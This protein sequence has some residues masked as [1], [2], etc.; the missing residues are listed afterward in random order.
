[1]CKEYYIKKAFKFNASHSIKIN[2]GFEPLH[3]HTFIA[4]ITYRGRK[5]QEGIIIDFHELGRFIEREILSTLD[6]SDLNRIFE[7]PTT[8]NIAEYI[9]SRADNFSSTLELVEVMVCESENSCIFIREKSNEGHTIRTSKS[10]NS[11]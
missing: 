3:G 5:N 9:W 8:E 2:G 1:M 10:Q 6:R 11:T 7:N 4:S